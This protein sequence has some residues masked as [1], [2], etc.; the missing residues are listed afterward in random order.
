LREGLYAVSAILNYFTDVHGTPHNGGRSMRFLAITDQGYMELMK[1][2]SLNDIEASMK[3]ETLT[4][5]LCYITE[6]DLHDLGGFRAVWSLVCFYKKDETGKTSIAS[7]LVRGKYS[8]VFASAYLEEAGSIPTL[9]EAFENCF[10]RIL[11][12]TLSEYSVSPEERFKQD[13]F[14]LGDKSIGRIYYVNIDRIQGNFRELPVEVTWV[15][16]DK[17]R[18]LNLDAFEL[19]SPAIWHEIDFNELP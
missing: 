9:D 3:D 8:L 7:Y 19:Y 12:S 15:E 4:R 18:T 5:H 11:D 16:W 2:E 10:N 14:L 13:Y 1:P 17:E 6:H